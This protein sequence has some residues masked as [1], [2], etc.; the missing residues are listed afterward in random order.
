MAG[1][2]RGELT[3]RPQAPEGVTYARK[4]DKAETRVNWTL[5]N[6]QVHD[7]IRGLSPFPGAWCEVEIAGKAERLKLLRSTLAEGMGEPGE[8]LDDLFTVGC[9]EGAIQLRE[10]QRAGGKPVSAE[11]FLRGAKT[12]KGMRLS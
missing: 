11:Q 9:G 12:R 6:R 8:I 7:H 3:L 2:E 4:I 1:L 10:V 5:A